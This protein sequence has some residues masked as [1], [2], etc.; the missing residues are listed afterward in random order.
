MADDQTERGSPKRQPADQGLP[1]NTSLQTGQHGNLSSSVSFNHQNTPFYQRQEPWS[2]LWYWMSA[3]YYQQYYYQLCSY[4]YY[5]QTVASHPMYQGA[6]QSQSGYF[7]SGLASRGSQAAYGGQ[8]PRQ[9][10]ANANNRLP[11]NNGVGIF[12]GLAVPWAF[13]G[14]QSVTTGTLFY[15]AM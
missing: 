8:Q 12:P 11:P 5:W 4:M 1:Q 15:V 14:Q 9:T 10:T 13:P 3:Q 6:S 2:V 7:Q